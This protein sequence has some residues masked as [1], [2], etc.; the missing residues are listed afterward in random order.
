MGIEAIPPQ[1][2]ILGTLKVRL[3]TVQTPWVLIN[4]ITTL[5]SRPPEL[6]S[7]SQVGD[8]PLIREN[9]SAVR[10]TNHGRWLFKHKPDQPCLMAS[11]PF[12]GIL[13]ARIK[14]LTELVDH[15]LQS[16]SQDLLHLAE[17]LYQQADAAVVATTRPCSQPTRPKPTLTISVQLNSTQPAQTKTH[18][19]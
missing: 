6:A 7:Q 2:S 3:A 16:A 18:P 19:P 8:Q 11:L 9:W 17:A 5:P 15:L 12:T 4:P 13:I 1:P 14:Q 10:Q